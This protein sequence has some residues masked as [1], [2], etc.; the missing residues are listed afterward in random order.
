MP[1]TT[2]VAGN[3]AMTL[4]QDAGSGDTMPIRPATTQA[5]FSQS[6]RLSKKSSSLLLPKSID[7]NT[8]GDYTVNQDSL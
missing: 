2:A 5:L 3:L 7:T 8:D 4:R 1:G 6:I